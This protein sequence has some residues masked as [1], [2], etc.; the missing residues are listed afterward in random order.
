VLKNFTCVD[1][2]TIVHYLKLASERDLVEDT[3]DLVN[4]AIVLSSISY[5]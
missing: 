5:F 1:D 2:N 3:T 4:Y